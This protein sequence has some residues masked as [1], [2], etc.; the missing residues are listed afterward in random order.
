[1]VIPANNEKSRL[2][3]TLMSV[4]E[5]FNQHGFSHEIIVVD[6]GSTDAT[7][8]DRL[9]VGQ[10]V[11]DH[12][13]NPLTPNMGKGA[14]VRTGIRNATGQYV[15]YNDAD[16]ATPVCRLD[17]LLPIIRDGAGCGDRLAGSVFVRDSY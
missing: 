13:S 15:M 12:S 5:Y 10:T 4:M 6:D 8:P 3:P 7:G 11:R 9:R 17:R 1:M 16:G 14:A 2:L